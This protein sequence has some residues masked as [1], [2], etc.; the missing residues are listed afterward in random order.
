M[1]VHQ[2]LETVTSSQ[3]AASMH[4]RSRAGEIAAAMRSTRV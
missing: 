1:R 4:H 3:P 2:A